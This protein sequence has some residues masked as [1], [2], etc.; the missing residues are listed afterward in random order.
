M[1][2]Q[3]SWVV[4]ITKKLEEEKVKINKKDYV[5]FQLDFIEKFVKHTQKYCRNCEICEANKKEISDIVER[6]P[7]YV[8]N[9]SADRKELGNKLDEIVKHLKYVHKL[10]YKGYF[11]SLF[12]LIGL[13]AGILLFG[14]IA[15]L[16]NPGFLKYGI[17]GGF[18]IGIIIGRITGKI[19]DKKIEKEGLL[20]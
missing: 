2:L 6:M 13:V 10:Q 14:G 8:N 16:I 12:S 11:L 1:E 3:D 4:Q 5:F 17:L 18:T 9:N 7:L 19:K 20:I 15:Y